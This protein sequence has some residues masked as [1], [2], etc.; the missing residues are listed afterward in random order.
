MKHGGGLVQ[1]IRTG[2]SDETVR[3]VASSRIEEEKI[4]N[5][6]TSLNIFSM[7]DAEV[8]AELVYERLQDHG[9]A[10]SFQSVH[11]SM[12]RSRLATGGYT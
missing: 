7:H 9:R 12:P 10:P 11:L 3:F 8:L 4:K 2:C 6:T 1:Q 5:V